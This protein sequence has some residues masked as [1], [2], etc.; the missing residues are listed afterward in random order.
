MVTQ[1]SVRYKTRLTIQDISE[2]KKFQE[3]LGE[4]P[5]DEIIPI[6]VPELRIKVKGKRCILPTFAH[7]Q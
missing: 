3:S 1:T 4:F 7:S 2:W 6:Q 5:M